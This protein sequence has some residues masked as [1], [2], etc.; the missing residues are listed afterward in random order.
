MASKPGMSQLQLEL[1]LLDL[2]ERVPLQE[3]LRVLAE[4]R[5]FDAEGA[6]SDGHR[7]TAQQYA[8]EA[9]I[10]RAAAQVCAPLDPSQR[11]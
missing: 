10:L 2:L 7:Q 11:C 3:L 1:L 5:G 4:L 8:R 9:R 6:A